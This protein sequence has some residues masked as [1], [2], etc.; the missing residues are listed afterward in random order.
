MAG[1]RKPTLEEIKEILTSKPISKDEFE[2][3]S[4]LT[5]IHNIYYFKFFV[6]FKFS[7]AKLFQYLKK[8]G[9]KNYHI[10]RIEELEELLKD[11]IMQYIFVAYCI[12]MYDLK[13][14]ITTSKEIEKFVD[15]FNCM[16]SNNE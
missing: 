5:R 1:V 12:A 10:K 4:G 9:K 7:K 6:Y 13:L 3:I 14:N 15:G 16:E 2:R 11:K 8:Q